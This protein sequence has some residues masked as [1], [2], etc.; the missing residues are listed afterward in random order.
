MLFVI[1]F[2]L[3]FVSAFHSPAPNE[4]RLSVIG[5]QA[6][7]T[8]IA[9]SLDKT[10]EFQVSQTD[11]VREAELD[12]KDRLAVGSL[13]V[14]M[15]DD[16]SQGPNAVTA[17]V[18]SGNGPS[19]AAVV[20]GAAEKV[21]GKLGVP[22][23]V[24]DVAPLDARDPMGSDLFYLLIYSTVGAFML[25]IVLAE[26]APGT[27][28]RTMFAVVGAGSVLIPP[29]VFGLSAVFVGDYGASIGT[30]ASVL[31]VDA[32]YVFTIGAIAILMH[33]FL[34]GS[35]LLGVLLLAVFF[36][37]PGSGGPVPYAM[38]P[39]FWQGIHSFSFGAGAME[40]F[41][42]LVY[43]DGRGVGRWILQLAAWAVAVPG[44]VAIVAL[45]KSNRHMRKR[46]SLTTPETARRHRAGVVL[47][48]DA[49]NRSIDRTA[50]VT[51]LLEGKIR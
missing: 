50:R 13:V 49:P 30:I 48:D 28:A 33:E 23:A 42:G 45:W 27:K 14:T 12:V 39:D 46:L 16:P 19:V 3:A 51:E 11:V 40:A 29:L 36:N 37:V 9:E 41:R 22:L 32:L 2:P 43:F 20:R 35:L 10:S 26:T 38:L 5:P 25:V 34:G 44:A 18:G 17:Y 21:A 31:A 6:V 4:M 24:K 7:V 1:A 8:D 47:P 15:H